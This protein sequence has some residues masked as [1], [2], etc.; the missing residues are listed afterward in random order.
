MVS[1][2]GGIRRCL[3]SGQAIIVVLCTTMQVASQLVMCRKRALIYD[4]MH[5]LQKAVNIDEI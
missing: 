4:R 5:L 3:L 1:D 2:W